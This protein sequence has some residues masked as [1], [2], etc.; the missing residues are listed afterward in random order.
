M[1]ET[2]EALD[3]TPQEWFS[4]SENG[5]VETESLAH[6]HTQH[7]DRKTRENPTKRWRWASD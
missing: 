7:R 4:P 5:Q 6:A 2:E 3:S 1:G